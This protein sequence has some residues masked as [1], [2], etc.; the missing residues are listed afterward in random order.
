MNKIEGLSYT[1]Q[2]LA[3]TIPLQTAPRADNPQSYADY[4]VGEMGFKGTIHGVEVELNGTAQVK[5][6]NGQ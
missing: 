1:T 6:S 2:I 3:A 4:A 5:P